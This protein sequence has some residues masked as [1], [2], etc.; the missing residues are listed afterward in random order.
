[1][2]TSFGHKKV[3]SQIGSPQGSNFAP[4]PAKHP[5]QKYGVPLGKVARPLHLLDQGLQNRNRPFL[6]EANGGGNACEWMK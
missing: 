6:N 5:D 3:K 4:P 2:Y 1:M